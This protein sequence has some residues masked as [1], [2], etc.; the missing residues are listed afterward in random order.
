MPLDLLRCALLVLTVASTAAHAEPS[1]YFSRCISEGTAPSY[2]E[3]LDRG[4][5]AELSDED[6]RL[7][8]RVLESQTDFLKANP[9]GVYITQDAEHEALAR[10]LGVT[11]SGAMMAGKVVLGRFKTMQI[12]TGY[13]VRVKC[14]AEAAAANPDAANP[15]AAEATPRATE[16]QAAESALQQRVAA[17]K[18]PGVDR[19]VFGVE[20]GERLAFPRCT[21]DD[22]AWGSLPFVGVGRGGKRTCVG[23]AMGPAM[24]RFVETADQLLGLQGSQLAV[25]RTVVTLA[26]DRCPEWVRRGGLCGVIVERTEDLVLGATVI[27]STE[28]YDRVV[29]QLTEKYGRP[30]EYGEKVDCTHRLSGVVTQEAN[31]LHWSLPGLHVTYDPIVSDC[32]RGRIHV[33]LDTL[34]SLRAREQESREAGEAKM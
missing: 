10:E 31:I 1:R 28:H 5:R 6:Y 8:V 26:D 7:F 15:A 2:C 19:T 29:D 17:D 13:P 4:L 24:L 33:E 9:K 20:L 21:D 27:P 30:P 34:R 3:C 12:K 14:D 22:E 16:R 18:R 23:G 32:K 25:K 11:A